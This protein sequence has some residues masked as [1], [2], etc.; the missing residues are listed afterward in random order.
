MVATTLDDAAA[1]VLEARLRH[2]LVGCVVPIV[3]LPRVDVDA[4]VSAV[5]L[6]A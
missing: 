4:P 2:V 5:S 3:R 1:R 6:R